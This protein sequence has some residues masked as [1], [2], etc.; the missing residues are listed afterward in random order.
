[1]RRWSGG[2]FGCSRSV[3][4]EAGQVVE[5]FVGGEGVEVYVMFGGKHGVG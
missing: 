4:E 2:V 1:M 3:R 5:G